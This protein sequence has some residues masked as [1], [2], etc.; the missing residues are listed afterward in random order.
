[1]ITGM[2]DVVHGRLERDSPARLS[3][4]AMLVV[5]S[6]MLFRLAISDKKKHL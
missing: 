3:V 5:V 4:S 1:M 2:P 6:W